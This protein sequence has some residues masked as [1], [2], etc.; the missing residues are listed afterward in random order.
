MS[1]TEKQSNKAQKM[2]SVISDLLGQSTSGV[3]SLS[4]AFQIRVVKEM[5][6]LNHFIGPDL[7][8]TKDSY[9]EATRRKEAIE[10]GVGSQETRKQTKN[11]KQ[12]SINERSKC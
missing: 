10:E 8:W 3:S 6:V 7:S 12:N 9:D 4:I 5:N 11:R 1:S 2:S